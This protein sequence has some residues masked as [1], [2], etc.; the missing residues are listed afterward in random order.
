VAPE[1]SGWTPRAHEN[2]E[3]R[4]P[5]A[6][7]LDAPGNLKAQDRIRSLAT[8]PNLIVPGHYPAVFER[9]TRIAEGIVRVR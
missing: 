4:V 5:I 1:G 6:Q 7:T 8:A 2:L 9:Y 3:K